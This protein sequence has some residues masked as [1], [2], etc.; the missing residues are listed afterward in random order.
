MFIIVDVLGMLLQKS[1]SCSTQKNT[2]NHG[3]G[4]SNSKM[5][6]LDRTNALS[7]LVIVTILESDGHD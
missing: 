7:W 4:D 3:T 6:M 1:N 5:K 2:R